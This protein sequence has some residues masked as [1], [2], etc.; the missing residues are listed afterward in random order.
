MYTYYSLTRLFYNLLVLI[1][2]KHSS[3]YHLSPEK[4]CIEG[5]LLLQFTSL[6]P[7]KECIDGDLDILWLGEIV[8]RIILRFRTLSFPPYLCSRDSLR[9]LIRLRFTMFY[10][11]KLVLLNFREKLRNE[12]SL[13]NLI[14]AVTYD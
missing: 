6:S 13:A 12:H 3:R 2:L 4:V 1:H 7:A 10:F 11:G 14:V 9:S 5:D 8:L